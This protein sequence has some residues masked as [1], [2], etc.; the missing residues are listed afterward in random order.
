M[1]ENIKRQRAKN[2]EELKKKQAQKRAELAAR[3]NANKAEARNAAAI[4]RQ[5][6]R[7]AEA[8][9]SAF[10]KKAQRAD[11]KAQLTNERQEVMSDNKPTDLSGLAYLLG[12]LLQAV[13]V[14]VIMCCIIAAIFAPDA[15]TVSTKGPRGETLDVHNFALAHQNL[16]A[17]LSGGFSCIYGRLLQMR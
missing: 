1:D 8:A 16:V 13:G 9:V 2:Y 15:L 3:M 4:E 11:G 6:R 7:E 5:A 10:R 12:G 17:L 14:F